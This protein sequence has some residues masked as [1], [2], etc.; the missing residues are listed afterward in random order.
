MLKLRTFIAL[1]AIAAISASGV[2]LAAS[3]NDSGDS[4]AVVAAA[5]QTPT[6]A[7]TAVQPDAQ[8]AFKLLR[9]VAPTP[10]PPDVADAVGS[11]QRFGRN[12]ALARSIQT[13]TG[14]GWVIPGDGFLCIAVPDPV[15]GWGTTCL[16]TAVAAQRGLGIGLTA[17]NGKS[18]ETL[19]VPDGAAATRLL[20]DVS[21]TPLAS[22]SARKS[23]KVTSSGIAT[24]HTNAPG[25]LR[26]TR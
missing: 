2:A 18:V 5:I 11:P 17:A 13:P 10:M 16:P 9:T 6:A 7:V 24:A 23:V 15:D 20:G 8:A 1:A 19:L 14:K 22:T 21:T 4:G 12:P 26:A 25:S 3:P